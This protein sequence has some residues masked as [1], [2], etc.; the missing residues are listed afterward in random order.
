MKLKHKR[1]PT[2]CI[3]EPIFGVANV[4]LGTSRAVGSNAVMW[5]VC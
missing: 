3:V 5:N 2:I 4:G 1:N